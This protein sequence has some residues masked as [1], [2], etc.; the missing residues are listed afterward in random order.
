LL[1]K[2]PRQFLVVKTDQVDVEILLLQ[3]GEETA[4]AGEDAGIGID[5]NWIGETK[6]KDASGDLGQS[7]RPNV[8]WGCEQMV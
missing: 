7:E 5:K 1:G 3:S 4:N 8:S 6:R 2:Q